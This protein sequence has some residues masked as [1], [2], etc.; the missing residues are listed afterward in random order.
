MQEKTIN[1]L[2]WIVG[3]LDTYNVE[4]QIAGGFAAKI[5][6]SPRA[7]NDIDFDI[8][9]DDFSKVLPEVSKYITFGPARFK[10]KK[11]D[12]ELITLNYQGQEIDISGADTIK[13]SNKERTTW[14][15]YEKSLFNTIPIHIEGINVKIIHPQ[16]LVNYKKELDGEHQSQ[17]IKAVENYLLLTQ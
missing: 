10:N 14:I 4:Y 7:V 1:A 17:D 15:S 13:M 3:I 11:W 8:H 16:E 2:K 9:D 6:G 5:Y 12:T